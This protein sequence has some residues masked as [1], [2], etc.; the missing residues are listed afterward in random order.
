MIARGKIAPLWHAWARGLSL[1]SA[2]SV[3]LLL[4]VY[5]YVLSGIPEWRVHT[6]LPVMMFGAAGLFMF[7]L[8]FRPRN[9]LAQALFYPG[10]AG[11]L[12]VAGMLTMVGG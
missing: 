2:G 8:G 12:F 10:L 6:G 5:P 1:A 4:L 7:G 9:R 3:S 11:L